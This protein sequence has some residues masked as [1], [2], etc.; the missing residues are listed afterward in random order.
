MRILNPLQH[1][2]LLFI[3]YLE[4]TTV[5]VIQKVVQLLQGLRPQR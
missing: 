3:M 2:L 5:Y 4:L 1:D